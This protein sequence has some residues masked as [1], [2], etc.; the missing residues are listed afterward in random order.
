MSNKEAF[1]SSLQNPKIKKKPDVASVQELLRTMIGWLKPL[2][3]DGLL[4]LRIPVGKPLLW[5]SFTA[6]GRDVY[7]NICP[8]N[9]VQ[10]SCSEAGT[11]KTV[12]LE[13]MSGVWKYFVGRQGRKYKYEELTEDIF[14]MHL[15]KLLSD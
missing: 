10:I 13:L 2:E 8:R 4:K 7:I 1:I 5:F 6:D 9:E 14:F 3:K 15:R 12:S 11:D